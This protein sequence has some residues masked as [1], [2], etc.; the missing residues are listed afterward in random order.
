MAKAELTH[1]AERDLIDIYLHGI[2]AHRSVN[3]GDG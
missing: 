1:E 3:H 2:E